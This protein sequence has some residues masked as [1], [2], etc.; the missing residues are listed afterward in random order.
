VALGQIPLEDVLRRLR[1]E[2]HRAEHRDRTGFVAGQLVGLS[3]FGG[4]RPTG[5]LTEV[6]LYE[7][8]L[9][10]ESGPPVS[11]RKIAVKYVHALDDL[12]RVRKATRVSRERAAPQ[13]EPATNPKDRY[14][15]SD[16]RLFDFL[17]RESDLE[18]LF[19]DGE[20]LHG[21]VSWV[22]R[23]EFGLALKGGAEAAVCRHALSAVARS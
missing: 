13:P 7:F 18:V 17:D 23:F 6:S 16:R 14:P 10:P 12:R 3:T 11:Y 15:L 22:S 21:R 8:V 1:F 5:R 20:V 4:S 9:A 19:L 2:Q